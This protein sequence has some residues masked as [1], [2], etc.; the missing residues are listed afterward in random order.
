MI[1]FV[2]GYKRKRGKLLVDSKTAIPILDM[3][4]NMQVTSDT[5]CQTPQLA[6]VRKRQM[7]ILDKD[8]FLTLPGRKLGSEKL[9]KVN[10]T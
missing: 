8:N 4:M 1:S 10:R 3:K 7:Q 5:L 6:P 2:A 9:T